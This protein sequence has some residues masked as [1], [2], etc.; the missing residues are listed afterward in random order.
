MP[1]IT[2]IIPAGPVNVT[3]SLTFIVPAGYTGPVVT[4]TGIGWP[5]P[6]IEWFSNSQNITGEVP[7]ENTN[8]T[9]SAFVT[10]TLTWQ[11]GFA[12]SDVGEYT[13]MVQ[14]N[15]IAARD[16]I[17]VTLD[18]SVNAP[19][20]TEPLNCSVNSHIALFQIRV[21]D[22]NCMEWEPDTEQ[23]IISSFEDTLQSVVS[24][25]CDSCLEG[26][27][28]DSLDCSSQVE[29]AAVLRGTVNSDE[30][31]STE[32]IFCALYS[33]QQSGPLVLFDDQLRLVDESCSAR[34]ESPVDTE[35]SI[36]L[37]PT[38][39]LTLIIAVGAAAGGFVLLVFL[40]FIVV[41]VCLCRLK[42]KRDKM[43]MEV[44]ISGIPRTNYDRYVTLTS[45]TICG[46]S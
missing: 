42:K 36:P 41:C 28:I 6:S 23:S 39:D 18:L 12:D 1:T 35:C 3:N 15:D 20:V 17:S 21:L 11:D 38:N 8:R 45:S 14:A 19:P 29:G 30:S 2:S 34:L 44:Y 26:L 9:D 46:S 40:V 27:A 7:T 33:W 43:N 13:C 32:D 16:M 4:C 37:N 24:T 31:S 10:A 5:T 22:A 25:R